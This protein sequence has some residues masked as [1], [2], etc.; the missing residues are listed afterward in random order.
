MKETI[1]TESP[2]T[3]MLCQYF[4]ICTIQFPFSTDPILQRLRAS[5]H[6]VHLHNPT[7]PPSGPNTLQQSHGQAHLSL[8]QRVSV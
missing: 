6:N 8:T 5:I 3:P 2:T 4:N 1:K 7:P